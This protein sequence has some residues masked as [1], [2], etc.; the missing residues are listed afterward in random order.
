MFLSISHFH[1]S[2][3][4]LPE[5]SSWAN[6]VLVL[7]QLSVTCHSAGYSSMKSLKIIKYHPGARCQVPCYWEDKASKMAMVIAHVVLII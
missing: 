1:R 5:I 6:P 4:T 2:F 3:R 7:F